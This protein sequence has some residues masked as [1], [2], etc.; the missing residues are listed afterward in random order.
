MWAFIINVIYD[1]SCEKCLTDLF[2]HQHLRMI[3]AQA[4]RGRG[5]PPPTPSGLPRPDRRA[6]TGDAGTHP[7]PPSR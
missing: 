1:Q 6:L 4:V 2:R 5:C 3:P 7:P